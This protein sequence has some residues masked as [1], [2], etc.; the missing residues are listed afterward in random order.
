MVKFKYTKEGEIMK[1]II[2]YYLLFLNKSLKATI[3][4]TIVKIIR[5]NSVSFINQIC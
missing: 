3:M 2:D 1:I 4:N 5:R